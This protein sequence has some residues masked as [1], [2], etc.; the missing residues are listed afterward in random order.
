MDD[1][2][3]GCLE[4]LRTISSNSKNLKEHKHLADENNRLD[5]GGEKSETGKDA[6]GRLF[7][8]GVRLGDR[9]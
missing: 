1:S 8:H 7:L 6:A 9:F 5:G 2:G 4:K 3:N